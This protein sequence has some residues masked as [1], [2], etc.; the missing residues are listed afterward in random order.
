MYPILFVTPWFNVYAYGTMM[1]I[2]Y[3]VGTIVAL[4][5]ASKKG[6]SPE[7][8]FDMLLFQ[9]VAGLAGSRLLFLWEYIGG[10]SITG[11]TFLNFEAGGLTFFG[12]VLASILS[13]LIFIRLNNLPFWKTM[14]C[15]GFALPLGIAIARFGCFLNGCCYGHPCL[16]PWGVI[17]PKFTLVKVHPTQ[18]YESLAGLIIFLF[19]AKFRKKA[20]HDGQVF[21]LCIVL[22]SVFRFII[23]FFRADNPIFLLGFSLSQ[24]LSILM[25]IIG[26]AIL[27]RIHSDNRLAINQ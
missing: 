5:E 15:I 16:Y 12:A 9:M 14:D 25:V 1:A 24:F 3:A 18:V 8:V 17:F 22:Y 19:L 21:V 6:L 20:S 4:R 27:K 13:N 7:S 10:A 23:E 2:G 11:K 26:V